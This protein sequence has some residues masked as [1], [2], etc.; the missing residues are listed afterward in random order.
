MFAALIGY[1]AYN[2]AEGD[3]NDLLCGICSAICFTTSLIPVIGMHYKSNALGINIRVC[4]SIFFVIFLISNFCFAG[5]GVRMPYYTI[6]NG[7]L[8]IIYSGILYKMLNI[9]SI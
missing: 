1:L 9:K 8:L 3:D 2:V 6:V 4:A 5:F 7:M